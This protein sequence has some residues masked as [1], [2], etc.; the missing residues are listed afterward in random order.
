MHIDKNNQEIL[1]V[2]DMQNDFVSGVLGNDYAKKIVPAVVEEIRQWKGKVVATRDTHF[3][4]TY[5]DSV[6]GKLLPIHC[7]YGTDGW[8][9]EPSIQKA[10]EDQAAT[11][12][13]KHN[14]GF[15]GWP[16]ALFG[17]GSTDQ[18]AVAALTANKGIRIRI[19]GTCTDIC[20]LSNLVVLRT[21]FP[22]AE[23]ELVE[24]ACAASF[25]HK[26]EPAFEMAKSMLCNPVK[27]VYGG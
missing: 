13:D 18:D 12:I 1:I 26:Q 10:L 17:I 6:E 5:G 11:F 23:I 3:P 4:E 25:P 9:I 15:I 7:A 24:G 22:D 2:V 8:K 16:K 19:V 20:N 27:T 21:W 14:F